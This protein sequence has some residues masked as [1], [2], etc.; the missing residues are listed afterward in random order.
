M[1]EKL[2]RTSGELADSIA[3]ATVEL[4]ELKRRKKAWNAEI[5]ERI[6]DLEER[7]DGENEQWRKL[8]EKGL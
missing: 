7:I 5:N 6:R 8:K 1:D 4:N 2:Q 3:Q